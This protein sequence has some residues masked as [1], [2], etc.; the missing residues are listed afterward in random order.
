MR[1]IQHLLGMV[2]LAVFL[3]NFTVDRGFVINGHIEGVK[4]STWVK[5]YILGRH[6]TLDSAITINGYFILKNKIEIPTTCML[7]CNR[8][9]ALLQVENVD[10][11]I[12]SPLK[13]MHLNCVIQGGKEQNL[14][15]ELQKLQQSCNIVTNRIMDSLR[16]KNISE[17]ERQQLI[18]KNKD[19]QGI[20]QKI[21]INFALRNPNSYY[22][23]D[24]LYRNRQFIP[25]DTL[26]LT[27]ENLTPEYKETSNSKALK[28]F[29]FEKIVQKGNPYIDFQ[30]KTLR[31][32]DFSL[33]SLKGKY[34]YLSFWSAA[35]GPC[36][37]ENRFFSHNFN[38]LPK[39]LS[40]V[41]FSMDKNPQA[42]INS[43]KTDSIIWHN[44]SDLEGENGRIKTQYG[45]Q[46]LPTSFLINREGV[47]IE[48]FLGSN[49]EIINRLKSLIEEDKN[50]R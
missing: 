25:R 11:T 42:W 37:M 12:T 9:Y 6:G 48:T 49:N 24:L 38:A 29:L 43:S 23:L 33:S 16:N 39:D 21:L 28:I 10:M 22:G 3:F 20:S 19:V 2:I 26:K 5:L 18:K 50:K 44:V 17:N 35:C 47:I 1:P 7:R 41:S 34:V 31:G 36:R 27:Y 30:V 32:E 46:S 14:Q 13:D 8:E 15:N 4:D 45:V 40:L